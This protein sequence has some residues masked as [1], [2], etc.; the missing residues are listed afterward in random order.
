MTNATS[1]DKP[2]IPQALDGHPKLA[3]GLAIVGF[4]SVVTLVSLM[5]YL[6]FT[7]DRLHF[8]RLGFFFYLFFVAVPLLQSFQLLLSGR[9]EAGRLRGASVTGLEKAHAGIERLSAGLWFAF[10]IHA[11]VLFV[12]AVTVV[13]TGASE[14]DPSEAVF[15]ALMTR[16]PIEALFLAVATGLG[17]F[18]SGLPARLQS[19]RTA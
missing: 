1:T 11:L 13:A 7:S 6:A 10:L 3:Y 8:E 17:L 19:K 16:G 5:A 4:A 9:I 15:T 2:I 18:L 12:A 14:G